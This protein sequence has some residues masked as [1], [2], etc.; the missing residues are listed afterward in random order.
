RVLAGRLAQARQDDARAGLRRVRPP[1]AGHVRKRKAAARKID[2]RAAAGYN[3]RIRTG[4]VYAKHRPSFSEMSGESM[5]EFVR[6]QKAFP[7]YVRRVA[8][9]GTGA[10]LRA[11][12]LSD[13]HLED[14]FSE[15][16]LRRLV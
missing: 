13:L 15:G 1:D 12:H 2:K 14:G 6:I 3:K 16:W 5:L 11:V 8:L 10:R 9:P 4:P 7:L